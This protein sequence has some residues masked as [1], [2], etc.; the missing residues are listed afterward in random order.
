MKLL[1]DTHTFL[2]AIGGS[3]RL[4]AGCRRAILDP[5]N[6]LLLSVASVWEMA[7]KVGLG[8]LRLGAPIPRLIDGARATLGIAILP[9]DLAHVMRVQDLPFHHRDPFDRLLVSQALAEGLGVLS[10]DRVFDRY[11]VKRIW[12]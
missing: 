12:R 7:I 9:I 2:W 6:E 3:T 5:G 10:A 1:F 4:G 8:K 11:G